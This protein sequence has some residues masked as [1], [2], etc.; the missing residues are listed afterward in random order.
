MCHV[1]VIEVDLTTTNEMDEDPW[2]PLHA[3]MS[4]EEVWQSSG[5]I[6]KVISSALLTNLVNINPPSFS[7]ETK[8]RLILI[9]WVTFS[10]ESK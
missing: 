3:P 5:L 4:E 8:S 10:S 9:A 7:N 6:A 2:D 1:Q